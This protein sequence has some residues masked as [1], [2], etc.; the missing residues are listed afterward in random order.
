MPLCFARQTHEFARPSAM[1]ARRVVDIHSRSTEY[2]HC[3]VIVDVCERVDL[4]WRWPLA[5]SLQSFAGGPFG[6][7]LGSDLLGH[8]REHPAFEK[9]PALGINGPRL[10]TDGGSLAGLYRAGVLVSNV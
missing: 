2:A 1:V 3:F 5:L 10:R 8:L 4:V 6:G 7:Q 9:R